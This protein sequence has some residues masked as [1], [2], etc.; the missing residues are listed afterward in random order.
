MLGRAYLLQLRP[1]ATSVTAGAIWSDAMTTVEVPVPAD[2][3]S[4]PMRNMRQWLDDMRFDALSFA[5]I[6]I[7]RRTVVRVKFKA[8]E[9]A[10]AFAEH[11]A[12]RVL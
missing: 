2:D 1:E 11:F 3:V 12:G 5:W 8:A 9:E 6:E 10:V 7:D 4:T